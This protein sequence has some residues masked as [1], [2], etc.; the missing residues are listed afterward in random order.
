MNWFDGVLLITIVISVITGFG[1]GFGRSV[2]GFI[3]FLFAVGAA[4]WFYAPLGFRLRGLIES[5]PAA[6]LT[7]FFVVFVAVLA[8][9]GYAETQIARFVKKNDLTMADRALGAGFG[10]LNGIVG[11]AVTILVFLTFYPQPVL[12]SRLANSYLPVISE[13]AQGVSQLAPEEVREGYQRARRDLDQ[14][15]PPQVGRGIDQLASH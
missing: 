10:V 14:V 11:A 12:K 1:K 13:V 6:N 5:K 9:G 4:L 7:A 8:L 2:T 15:A 3:S